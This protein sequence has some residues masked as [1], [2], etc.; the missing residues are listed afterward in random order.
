MDRASSQKRLTQADSTDIK[1]VLYNKNNEEQLFKDFSNGNSFVHREPR[2]V[3][4]S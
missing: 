2:K 4:K 3:C 1:L